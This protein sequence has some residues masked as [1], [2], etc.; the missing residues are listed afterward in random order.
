VKA[1]VGKGRARPAPAKILRGSLRA[2]VSGREYCMPSTAV[3]YPG[4]LDEI[5]ETLAGMG[6]PKK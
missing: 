4:I 6:Y 2:I 1:G 5:T 3:D